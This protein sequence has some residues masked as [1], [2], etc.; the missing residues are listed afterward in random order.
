MQ[1]AVLFLQRIAEENMTVHRTFARNLVSAI[2]L[3]TIVMSAMGSHRAQALGGNELSAG[4]KEFGSA[5]NL[6]RKNGAG[7]FAGLRDNSASIPQAITG[8]ITI[9]H[10]FESGSTDETAFIQVIQ[11]AE[12]ANPGLTVITEFHLFGDL[13]NDYK[14]AVDAGGGPDMY[15]ANSDEIGDLA[16]RGYILNIDSY[17]QGQLT[18]VQQ[19]A[20]DGVRVN[21][22]LYGVP[23]NAKAVGLFYNKSMV[24]TPPTTTT[25]LLSLLQSGETLTSPYAGSYW[26]FGFWNAFGGQIMDGDGHCIATQGGIVPAMQYLVSLKNAGASLDIDYEEATSKFENVSATV[27]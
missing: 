11:N 4:F 21:G 18:N 13:I 10:S 20:I 15:L 2:V 14:A 12:A 1:V 24:P 17:L 27:F 6:S 8:T 26:F 16:R 5:I 23:E 7:V 3:L 19:N 25:E 22:Q 9:W